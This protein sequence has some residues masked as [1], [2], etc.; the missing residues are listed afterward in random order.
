M[1]PAQHN[2]SIYY[3]G[4]VNYVSQEGQVNFPF[5][6]KHLSTTLTLAEFKYTQTTYASTGFLSLTRQAMI[7]FLIP[8]LNNRIF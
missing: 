1:E 2:K 4:H 3:I 6:L 5:P 7:D 8:K